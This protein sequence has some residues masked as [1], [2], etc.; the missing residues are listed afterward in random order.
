MHVRP[1]IRVIL[2]MN[3]Q[4]QM[5]SCRETPSSVVKTSVARRWCRFFWRVSSVALVLSM[6]ITSGTVGAQDRPIKVSAN[7]D[8]ENILLHAMEQRGKLISVSFQY[9]MNYTE[10]GEDSITWRQTG[11]LSVDER[12]DA[13]AHLFQRIEKP[14]PAEAK[15]LRG[16]RETASEGSLRWQPG[17]V[18][19]TDQGLWIC[20]PEMPRV[21]PVR[22]GE[23]SGFSYSV[24]FAV[25]GLGF[26]FY[27][28]FLRKDD[29]DLAIL[30]YLT[31]P[32]IKTLSSEAGIDV[33]KK[34][35]LSG[36]IDSLKN[37]AVVFFNAGGYI[38]AID[39]NRDYWPLAGLYEETRYVKKKDGSFRENGT[40]VVTNYECSVELFNGRWV[41]KDFRY[42]GQSGSHVVALQWSQCNPAEPLEP[43][44]QLTL[45]NHVA[46]VMDR[47]DS[48]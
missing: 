27:G 23:P 38:L 26:S 42:S 2:A 3:L 29:L 17:G 45:A 41:P 6:L 31:Y 5:P 16:K 1:L 19:K 36:G 4:N 13:F 24:P 11:E 21:R 39:T 22:N 10:A 43:F 30:P 44:N 34:T 12:T 47:I 28:N 15:A 14:S 25:R 20:S 18:V 7:R 40:Q 48:K 33:F 35:K 8:F 32:S 46:D 37:N 9:Q